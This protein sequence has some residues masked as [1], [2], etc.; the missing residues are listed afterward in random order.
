MDYSNFYRFKNYLIETK[1]IPKEKVKYYEY[2]LKQFICL[3]LMNLSSGIKSHPFFFKIPLLPPFFTPVS[4]FYM[5]F[6]IN[7]A[8]LPLRVKYLIFTPYQFVDI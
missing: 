7:Q 4:S 6:L 3:I 8:I 1:K 5:Y 2:W